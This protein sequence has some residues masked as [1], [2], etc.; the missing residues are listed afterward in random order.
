[1]KLT[2]FRG[3]PGSGKSTKARALQ[4]KTGAILIEPDM[5]MMEHGKYNYTPK[6]FAEAVDRCRTMLGILTMNECDEDAMLFPD[7]IY[8]DVL[9]KLTDVKRLIDSVDI[10]VTEHSGSLEVIDCVITKAQSK[11]RNTHNVRREDIDRMARDWEPWDR[12]KA[13]VW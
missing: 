4:A 10:P 6:R 12:K 7:I 2:I 9:P 8:A 3:L 11:K 5:L 1:M 13:G